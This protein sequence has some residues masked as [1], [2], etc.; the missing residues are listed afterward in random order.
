LQDG[1]APH[2][3]TVSHLIVVLD[4]WEGSK[5]AGSTSRFNKTKFTGEGTRNNQRE[6]SGEKFFGNKKA[7]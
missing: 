1:D 2:S 7:K 5:K 4:R 3:L 6:S